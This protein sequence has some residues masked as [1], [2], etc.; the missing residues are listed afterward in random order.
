M[1][2]EAARVDAQAAGACA[3]CG[4]CASASYAILALHCAECDIAYQDPLPSH[5]SF[6]SPLGACDTCRGFG[7]VIGV[8]Y[9]LVIPDQDKTLGGGAIKPWQPQPARNART[10]WQARRPAAFR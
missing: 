3:G 10:T 7:R 4:G 1:C 8:D 2:L 9:E 5:F 6:N